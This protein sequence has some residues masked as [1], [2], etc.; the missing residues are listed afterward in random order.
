MFH[1]IS[2]WYFGN[3]T[4]IS[5]TPIANTTRVNLMVMTLMGSSGLELLPHV[6]GLKTL[7]P[8]GPVNGLEVVGLKRES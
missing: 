3:S 5:N 4:P 1:H 2:L 8:K 6:R 7:A